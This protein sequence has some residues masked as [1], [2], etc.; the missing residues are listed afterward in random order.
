MPLFIWQSHISSSLPFSSPLFPTPSSHI[1]S[2]LSP[3]RRNHFSPRLLSFSLHFPI[4]AIHFSPA[5]PLLSSCRSRFSCSSPL[6]SL[7]DSFLLLLPSN[8]SSPFPHRPDIPIYTLH[9][10]SPP[11]D[12]LPPLHP[13]FLASLPSTPYVPLPLYGLWS[14]SHV[15]H[16]TTQATHSVHVCMYS[17]GSQR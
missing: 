13:P 2:L 16:Y 3:S 12:S 15:I 11:H 4:L 10:L 6:F 14:V 1:S 17:W 9:I 8:L 5:V 7:S